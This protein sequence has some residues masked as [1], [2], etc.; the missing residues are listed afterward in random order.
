[1]DLASLW[2]DPP[3]VKTSIKLPE[4]RQQRQKNGVAW[5]RA[6]QDRSLRVTMW[7]DGEGHPLIIEKQVEF[8]LNNGTTK[9]GTALFILCAT[10][11]SAGFLRLTKRALQDLRTKAQAR[12]VH[13]EFDF[14]VQREPGQFGKYAWQLVSGHNVRPGDDLWDRM[15]WIAEKVKQGKQF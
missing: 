15:D 1:V 10:A 12:P 7:S 13:G 8:K 9:Q 14:E 5:F 2:N 6:R 11:R 3:K 4:P